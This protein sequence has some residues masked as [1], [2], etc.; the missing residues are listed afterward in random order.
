MEVNNSVPVIAVIPTWLQKGMFCRHNMKKRMNTKII[1]AMMA[2]FLLSGCSGDDAND[3]VI[4]DQEKSEIRIDI[5]SQKYTRANIIDSNTELQRQALRIDAYYHGTTTPYLSNTKL[6]YDSDRWRFDDGSGTEVHYYWPIEGSVTSTSITV[7]SLDF[8]GFCP[9]TTPSYI[10]TGPTYDHSTGITFTCNMGSYMTLSSQASMSEYLVAV[11]ND[12]TYAK[13]TVAGGA[14]P[15]EFKHPF[16]LI[17]FVITAASGTN[18]KINSI[19]LSEMK[20]TG[21]CAYNGTDLEWSSQGG[22][23]DIILTQTLKNGGTTEGTPFVVIP[24][25]YGTKTLTVNATWDDWSDVTTNVTANV[26]FNWQAGYIYTYNLTLSKYALKV[27]I[28]DFTEQW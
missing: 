21:T 27:D 10:T 12:Q 6:R 2:I 17:K 20:T 25:D 3:A 13:Q 5:N 14:L 18:V 23:A 1:L 19:S 11:L 22:S 7:G 15:L 8:V 24:N 4:P 26:A 28:T 9:F 16:A